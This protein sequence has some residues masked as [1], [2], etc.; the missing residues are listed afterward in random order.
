MNHNI[1]MQHLPLAFWTGTAAI[2]RDISKW[3]YFGF[4]FEVTADVTAETRFKLQAAPGSEADVCVPGAFVDVKE[5]PLCEKPF[6][7]GPSDTNAE[8]VIPAGTKAGTI[9][10][11][12]YPCRPNRYL[13]LA[14]TT[15]TEHASVRVGIV[16]SG[17]Q[18]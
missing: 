14:T 4:A 13:Q 8:I 3:N 18:I 6:F 16:L 15:G 2:P 1:A 7:T 5:I 9:C 10:A 17:P 11:V 12:S